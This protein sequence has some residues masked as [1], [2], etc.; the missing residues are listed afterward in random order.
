MNPPVSNRTKIVLLG[1]DAITQKVLYQT[2]WM[3]SK[4]FD[5]TAFTT[6]RD[7]T[8]VRRD[9][10]LM[11]IRIAPGIA[12]RLAQLLRFLWRHRHDLHHVELYVAGRFAFVYASMCRA[13]RIPVLVV[14]RGDLLFCLKRVY[15]RLMRTSIY[16]CYLLATRIWLRE[17]YMVRFF[18][19]WHL[20]W[21]TFLLPNAVPTNGEVRRGADRVTDFLFVNRLIPERHPIRLVEVLSELRDT[22]EV[23]AE[24]VGL[25][26]PPQSYGTQEEQ[27]AVEE[28]AKSAAD[29]LKLHAFGNPAP[30]YERARFFVLP[31]DVVF[32]N[33]ALLEA[34]AAGVVPLVSAVEGADRIVESGV[35]GILFT[36]SREG[37][38]NAL[39]EALQMDRERWRQLSLAAHQTVR[40]RYGIDAWGHTLL[41]EYG[42]LRRSSLS[43]SA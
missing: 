28:R 32:A 1:I 27:D 16:L 35:N 39:L 6:S 2:R 29:W 14:E 13:L 22:Y 40:E 11:I 33:F 17:L 7:T 24:I 5:L 36:H 37:L 20:S 26:P 4:G 8:T 15:P 43:D 38:K 25:L 30:F 3:Q 21:K 18:E 19:R 12:R 10:S 34:M 41:K 31:A 42:R 23:T 9:Q